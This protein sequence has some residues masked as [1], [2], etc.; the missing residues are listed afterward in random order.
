MSAACRWAS[1]SAGFWCCSPA[2]ATSPPLCCCRYIISPTPRSHWYAASPAASAIWQAHRT[3]FYQIATDR[4]FSILGV[5]VRVFVVNVC[6]GALAVATIVVPGKL[7]DLG[8][9]IAGLLLVAWLLA[10][11]AKGKK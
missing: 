10:A 9:F 11:F 6:L 5:V 2:P 4:G 1:C 8:A 7:S 3:H